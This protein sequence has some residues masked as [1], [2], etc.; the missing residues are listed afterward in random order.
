MRGSTQGGFLF[1]GNRMTKA[2]LLP[3]HKRLHELFEYKDGDLI[4]KVRKGA[5][6]AG[7]SAKCLHKAS[8]RYVTR[9]DFNLHKSSRIIYKMHNPDMDE[10]LVVDHINGNPMDDRIENLRTITVRQNFRNLK[11]SKNAKYGY[12][13]IRP[14]SWGKWNARIMV[15]RKYIHL[16]NHETK[17]DAIEARKKAEKKYGFTTIL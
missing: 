3:D 7:K 9:F 16:G 11:L 17:E 15:N 4:W 2:K 6:Q 10:S 8:Q 1:G 5:A 13:G 12:P 14:L